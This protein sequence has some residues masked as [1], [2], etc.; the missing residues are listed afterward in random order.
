MEWRGVKNLQ[1]YEE[2]FEK[3]LETNTREF[4]RDRG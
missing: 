4:F 1:I 2:E 3:Q